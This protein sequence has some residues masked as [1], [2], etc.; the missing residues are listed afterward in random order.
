MGE[1]IADKIMKRSLESEGKTPVCRRCG[2]TPQDIGWCGYCGYNRDYELMQTST[3][4]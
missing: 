3:L 4:H 1:N 2:K